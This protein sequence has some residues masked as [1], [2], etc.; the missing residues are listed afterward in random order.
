MDVV[1]HER[2]HNERERE[3]LRSGA[4]V[5]MAFPRERDGRG[6]EDWSE[7]ARGERSGT[8]G[9]DIG[10]LWRSGRLSSVES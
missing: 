8:V 6:I 10:V 2:K 3:R 9:A 5:E 7:V 4:D 1:E